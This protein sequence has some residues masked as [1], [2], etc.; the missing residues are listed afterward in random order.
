V[1][2]IQ[3]AGE[4]KRLLSGL[5]LDIVDAY[6]HHQMHNDLLKATKQYPLVTPQSNTFWYTTLKA[7]HTT[8]FSLLTKA[9]DQEKSALHLYS[10]LLTIKEHLHLFGDKSFRERLK[11]NPFVE[12]LAQDYRI[13]DSNVLE[14]DILSCSAADPLVKTLIIH[15][16]SWVAHRSARNTATGT[17]IGDQHPLT[18]EDF[19]AL[20]NRAVTIL[21]RYS[22]LFEA[23]SYSTT[24]IGRAD[25]EYIFKCVQHAVEKSREN[26]D[27]LLKSRN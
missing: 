5:A 3:N 25:Y 22:V 13:P 11:D 9:F 7:H 6:I 26:T 2:K 15:R 18:W 8:S 21:N 10:W 27:A 14:E 24:P 20:L 4:F 12:S 16:S 17:S 23:T 1:I 19:E